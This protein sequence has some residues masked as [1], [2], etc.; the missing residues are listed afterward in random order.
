MSDPT[1]APVLFLCRDLMFVGR[2]TATAR[3]LNI[4]LTMIRD[5]AKL[6]AEGTKLIVD[7]NL[8][9]ALTAGGSWKAT[10][11]GTLVGFVQHVDTVAIQAAKEAGYDQVMPRSRFV[12]ELED[13]LKG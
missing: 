10:T 3:A 5:P 12:V 4:P 11:S 2:V 9:G 7:L 8:D 1:L 13:L 6:P